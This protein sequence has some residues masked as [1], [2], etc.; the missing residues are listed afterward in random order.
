MHPCEERFR[1]PDDYVCPARYLMQKPGSREILCCWVCPVKPNILHST[2]YSEATSALH[3]KT[4][5]PYC[6]RHKSWITID[7]RIEFRRSSQA[8][9]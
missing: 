8:P 7:N 5:C 4:H 9:S 2:P 1:R 6:D 3:V